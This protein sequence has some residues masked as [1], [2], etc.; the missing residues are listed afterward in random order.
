MSQKPEFNEDPGWKPIDD[1]QIY[2][3]DE[4]LAFERQRL[5]EIEQLKKE[6]KVSSSLIIIIVEKTRVIIILFW[7]FLIFRFRGGG[8]RRRTRRK[9][10]IY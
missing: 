6:G 7:L 4:W 2:T 1:Q 10:L 8:W 9:L 3:Q 5:A